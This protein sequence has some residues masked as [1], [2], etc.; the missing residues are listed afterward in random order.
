MS[1]PTSASVDAGRLKRAEIISTVGA[2]ILGGGL[3]LLLD[4]LLKPY[5][6]PLLLAG[7]LTHSWGMRDK[8]RLETRVAGTRVWWVEALYLGCWAALIALTLYLAAAKL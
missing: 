8:H 4:V 7:L 2:G 5:T 3:A 6:V 1:D